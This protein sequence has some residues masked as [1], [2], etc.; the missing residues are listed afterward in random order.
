[1]PVLGTADLLCSDSVLFGA[2][3]SEIDDPEMRVEAII[4]DHQE[5]LS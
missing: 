1:M 5:A 2:P 3:W 4:D